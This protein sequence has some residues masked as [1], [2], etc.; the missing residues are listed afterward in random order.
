MHAYIPSQRLKKSRCACT[1]RGNAG[2]KNCSDHHR[3][4]NVTASVVGFKNKNKEIVTFAKLSS[5]VVNPRDF[6]GNAEGEE[7]VVYFSIE[8]ARSC[9]R[10]RLSAYLHAHV[11]F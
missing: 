2:N 7:E 5:K 9:E 10:I 11:L 6:A 3:R 8:S 4:W 1:R